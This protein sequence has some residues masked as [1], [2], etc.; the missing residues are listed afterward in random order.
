M[1][2]GP[3]GPKG[4]RGRLGSNQGN[5]AMLGRVSL[6]GCRESVQSKTLTLLSGLFGSDTKEIGHGGPGGTSEI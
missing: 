5:L 2:S 1:P 4:D 3:T 6:R